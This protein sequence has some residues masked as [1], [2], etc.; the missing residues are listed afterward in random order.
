MHKKIIFLSIIIFTI[1]AAV[2]AAPD[3]YAEEL[4]IATG[5]DAGLGGPYPTDTDGLETIFSN[6]AAFKSADEQ[7]VFSNTTLHMKGPIYDIASLVIS[8]VS[9]GE[10][11]TSLLASDAMQSHP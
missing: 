5:V 7:F 2:F 11:L 10:E 6:P 1:T 8:S 9:A 3:Y 4:Y